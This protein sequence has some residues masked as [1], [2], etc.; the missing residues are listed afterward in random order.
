MLLG[1][2]RNGVCWTVFTIQERQGHE[3]WGTALGQQCRGT[4]SKR[5]LEGAA[6]PEKLGILIIDERL[7]ELDAR[8]LRSSI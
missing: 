5:L 3:A 1:Q 6:T 7:H 8:V 4:E 2:A